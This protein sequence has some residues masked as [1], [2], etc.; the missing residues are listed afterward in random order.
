M[1]ELGGA[2]ALKDPD[3]VYGVAR[4][5]WEKEANNFAV[6]C[7]DLKQAEERLAVLEK[8]SLRRIKMEA[9]MGKPEVEKKQAKV[10]SM[11]TTRTRS[12]CMFCGK[13]NHFAME[14]RANMEAGEKRYIV[15]ARR[16]CMKCARPHHMAKDCRSQTWCEKCKSRMHCVGLHGVFTDGRASGSWEKSQ[17][18]VSNYTRTDFESRKTDPEKEFE[19]GE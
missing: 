10:L 9:I 13:E 17:P 15:M 3:L 14:C 16:L 5:L 7:K 18:Q 1:K 2:F 19:K 4:L 12:G 6:K 11:E 8:E